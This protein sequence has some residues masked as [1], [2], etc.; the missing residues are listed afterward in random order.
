MTYVVL[1]IET[2][3]DRDL[4]SPPEDKPDAFAP[5]WAQRVVCWQ[6]MMVAKD[7][8]S[9]MGAVGVRDEWTLLESFAEG[10]K[11][12]KQSTTPILVTWNGRS[13]DFPVIA[14]R[15]LKHGIPVP[16]YYARD[17]R[18]RFSDE[19]HLD[20]CD[21]FSDHGATTKMTLDTCAKLCGIEG[22]GDMTGADVEVAWQR[23]EHERIAAY[24]RRD[25]VTTALLLVRYKYLRGDLTSDAAQAWSERIKAVQG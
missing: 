7:S 5:P 18:Y 4:W 8:A 21:A 19:G 9:W 14:L 25:V 12:L 24:C 13:F 22:K 1:D 10:M 15:S 11:R 6:A 3:P 2:I 16:W 20:L 17:V 23:G